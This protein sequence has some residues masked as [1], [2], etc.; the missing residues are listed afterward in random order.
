MSVIGHVHICLNRLCLGWC[1]IFCP[2]IIWMC[3]VKAHNLKFILFSHPAPW[4][5]ANG[6]DAC[7][8]PGSGPGIF[9]HDASREVRA[10]HLSLHSARQACAGTGKISRWSL[11]ERKGQKEQFFLKDKKVATTRGH[12]YGLI[13]SSASGGREWHVS[14]PETII[15]N[16][17]LRRCLCVSQSLSG[18]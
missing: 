16:K 18:G 4:E 9:Y 10:R 11:N 12:S 1:V 7:C 6:I 3:T 5:V 2:T 13:C 15:P 8:A 17:D 14:L